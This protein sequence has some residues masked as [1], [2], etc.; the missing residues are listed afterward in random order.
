MTKVGHRCQLFPKHGAV[1]GSSRQYLMLPRGDGHDRV[2]GGVS[3]LILQYV[4]SSAL[5]SRGFTL[6]APGVLILVALTL[7]S[8]F[9]GERFETNRRRPSVAEIHV[10]DCVR[11]C[12]RKAGRRR[13]K[14][15][16]ARRQH[17]QDSVNVLLVQ[18]AAERV[19]NSRRGFEPKA[20]FSRA[21]GL[22]T[23]LDMSI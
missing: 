16:L 17:R 23:R 4:L 9:P 18:F 22:G 11:V 20:H 1:Q 5:E 7:T 6:F 14:G 10:R 15:R 8:D 21:A 19:H 2:V 12:R 3:R 13:R